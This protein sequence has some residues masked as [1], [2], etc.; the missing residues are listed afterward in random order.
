MQKRTRNFIIVLSI[1][2][3]AYMALEAYWFFSDS[4]LTKKIQQNMALGMSEEALAECEKLH[5]WHTT[6][7]SSLKVAINVSNNQDILP[8]VCNDIIVE[9]DGPWWLPMRQKYIDEMESR[10]RACITTILSRHGLGQS[11]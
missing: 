8:Y 6:L 1:L 4:S 3:V 5:Y 10:K 2:V 7:C 9:Y 11:T